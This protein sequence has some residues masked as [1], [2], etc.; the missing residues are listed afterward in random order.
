M[1]HAQTFEQ[2]VEKDK[3]D[4]ITG[5]VFSNVMMAIAPPVTEAG[6][7]LLSA[8]AGPSPLAG[9]GCLQNLFTVSWQNDQTHA[10]MGKY[11]Q[12]K[13]VKRLYLMAPN[14]ERPG[15]RRCM[16]LAGVRHA[17]QECPG[18]TAS[19]RATWEGG[20]WWQR[21]SATAGSTSPSRPACGRRR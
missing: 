19:G 17:S 11:L 3:V 21:L 9:V 16:A 2:M 13:D 6:V 15:A 12:D 20:T 1:V 18:A 8:N 14:P 4:F 7:F 5:V 10:A